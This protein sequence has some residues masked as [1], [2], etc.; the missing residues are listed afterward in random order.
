MLNRYDGSVPPGPRPM[1][2]A[3]DLRRLVWEAEASGDPAALEAVCRANTDAIVKHFP[4]WQTLPPALRESPADAERYVRAM[5]RVAEV[6]EQRLGR[7][8]L[9]R[10]LRG[11]DS[12]PLVPWPKKLDEA[13]A[14]MAQ[15]G[16]AE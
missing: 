9:M 10:R 3:D 16:Y 2:D 1:S 13:R 7:P 14:P 8:E 12:N 5:V 4:A 6:F 15:P 11:D